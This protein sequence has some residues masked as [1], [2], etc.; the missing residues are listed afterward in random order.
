LGHAL[1]QIALWPLDSGHRP[2]G[3]VTRYSGDISHYNGRE[4]RS[5][6]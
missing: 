5:G 2:G 6:K 3:V 4:M 1:G